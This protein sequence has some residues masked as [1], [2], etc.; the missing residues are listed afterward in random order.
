MASQTR[1]NRKKSREVKMTG[2][3]L[4]SCLYATL[5]SSIFY[6]VRVRTS[7]KGYIPIGNRVK[8]EF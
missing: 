8:F 4:L 1:D 5:K 2:V 3:K 6:P 7:L